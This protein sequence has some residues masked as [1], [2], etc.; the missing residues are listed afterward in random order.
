[1]IIESL[2]MK[3]FKSHRN[4]RIDFDTGISIIIGGNG[5]GKSSILEAVSFALFKQHTSKRI[6][7]L[8]TI[9]QKRM[10]VEIQFTAHGRTYRVL[11]ERTKT[12][13]KAIM[14]IKEGRRFQSLVSGDKQVT[15]EVQDLLEMD[16]DLFLNAVYVRQGEI[17][18]LIEKTSSEK[19]QM[20]GRLLGIDSLEKAW[21]NI[22]IILDK[23][24]E[25][26]LILEGR[27]ESFKEFEEELNS[28][29]QQEA[30]FNIKIKNL[31]REIEEK[32]IDTNLVREKKEILDKRSLEFEKTNTLLNSKEH[33]ME[34]L[35]K[36]KKD[37]DYQLT[38]IIYKEQEIIKLK[39]KLSKLEVLKSLEEKSKELKDL[40]KDKKRLVGVSE[41]I[42]RF[43]KILNDNEPYYN[44]YSLLNNDINTLQYAKDQYEGS[45]VL[46]EQYMMRKSK[47]EDK[48]KQIPGKNKGYP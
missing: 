4:T 9:G 35:E 12:S 44:D 1:M 16:G 26:K 20:I 15:M 42:Q 45:R 21:K 33:F 5:V 29:K 41:D 17:A 48:I 40:N 34:Q 19:K 8:I 28:K 32:I 47:I 39:P 43:E 2:H 13:S 46:S 22:K 27:L 23:Y 7:K 38:E 37:L 30:E 31:N 10:E 36:T 11:R 6:D 14:S 25:K 3:N 24:N 18:D